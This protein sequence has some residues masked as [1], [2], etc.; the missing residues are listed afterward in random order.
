MSRRF[1]K[2]IDKGDVQLVGEM[3]ASKP[4]LASALI[5]WGSVLC[6]C[7]NEP[8]HYLSDR[9]FNQLWDH[10]KQAELAAVLIQAGTP[11]NGLLASGETPLHGAASANIVSTRMAA[12]AGNLADVN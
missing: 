4:E 2:A 9:I 1:R 11:V 5:S 10:G 12:G 3:L 6:P 7:S 8:L